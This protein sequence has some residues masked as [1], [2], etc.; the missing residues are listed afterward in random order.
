MKQSHL[1]LLLA[2]TFIHFFSFG[3]NPPVAG[4]SVNQIYTSQ[5][6]PIGSYEVHLNDASTGATSH[7]HEV[8]YPN[9]SSQ[10]NVTSGGGPPI[11]FTTNAI[12]P[13]IIRQIAMNSFGADTFDLPYDFIC[14]NYTVFP[15]STYLSP[16]SG[17]QVSYGFNYSSNAIPG[18]WLTG[19]NN[20]FSEYCGQMPQ[21]QTTLP[22][23]GAYRVCSELQQGT[24]PE[25][26]VCDTFL[27]P[28]WSSPDAEF[29]TS[30]GGPL[31]LNFSNSGFFDPQA[32]FSWTFGDG[33][34][35]SQ[36]AP[37]HTYNT[38]GAYTICLTITDNCGT[39]TYCDTLQVGPVR[40]DEP[41]HTSDFQLN[42]CFTEGQFRIEVDASFAALADW[43]LFDVR[44]RR[45]AARTETLY[46]GRTTIRTGTHSGSGLYFFRIRVA[47]RYKTLR[48]MSP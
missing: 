1:F 6:T 11:S 27:V 20:T 44:G 19:L 8:W 2:C 46:A 13:C 38:N 35:S 14:A 12:G 41:Q 4:F 21:C 31:T 22:A 40:L 39:D 5:F 29:S 16:G 32:T 33:G 47:N 34:S 36:Q 9:F 23:P 43:T 25:P 15:I 3:Q 18:V 28:C 24:C 17:G 48:L 7:V 37:T 30:S 42:G 45:L 26:T 10:A